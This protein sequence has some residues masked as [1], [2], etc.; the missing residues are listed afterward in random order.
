MPKLKTHK[1]LSKRV[2][3]SARGK[4]KRKRAGMSHLMSGKRGKVKLHLRRPVMSIGADA[5]KIRR[6]LGRG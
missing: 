2:R 3:I 6:A 5:K 1:G 4:V